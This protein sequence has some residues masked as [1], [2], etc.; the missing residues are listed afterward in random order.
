M[1]IEKLRYLLVIQEEASIS[2]AANRLYMSQPSLSKILLAIE[3][4]LGYKLFE[5]ASGG[6]VPTPEGNCYL[7]YAREA[8]DAE[9]KVLADMAALHEEANR[10]RIV[11][12]LAHTRNAITL[13]PDIFSRKAGDYQVIIRILRDEELLKGVADGSIDFA[14]MTITRQTVFPESIRHKE[15]Y[16]E[17]VLVGA[18]KDDPICEHASDMMGS[19]YPYLD[20]KY[21]NGANIVLSGEGTGLY[22]ICQ[23]FFRANDINPDIRIFEDS[24]QAVKRF[25]EEGLADICFVNEEVVVKAPS[26][27]L[28]FFMTD[29]S[30]P[31]RHVGLIWRRNTEKDMVVQQVINNSMSVLKDVYANKHN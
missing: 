26:D 22:D 4:T 15:L 28:R 21:L 20:P 30:M 13:P 11:F 2:Q 5:R 25:V 31:L 16:V 29:E 10:K 17:H 18:R 8:V 9:E 6:M 23:E 27:K 14:M 19:P 24:V 7:Q 12:G 1:E 3:K